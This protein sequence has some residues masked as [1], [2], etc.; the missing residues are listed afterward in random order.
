MNATA[1]FLRN[2]NLL[3][4]LFSQENCISD[5]LSKLKLLHKQKNNLYNETTINRKS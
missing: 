4:V 5:A 1:Y 3:E 2:I